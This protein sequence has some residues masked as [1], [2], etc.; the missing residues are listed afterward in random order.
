MNPLVLRTRV[1]WLRMSVLI[2]G[3]SWV[4]NNDRADAL[5][6]ISAARG[7]RPSCGGAAGN[8][9]SQL[10]LSSTSCK[11]P[12]DPFLLKEERDECRD[13]D[14]LVSLEPSADSPTKSIDEVDPLIFKEDADD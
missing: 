12:N 11:D 13:G 9:G 14:R 4:P 2:K 7:P 5:F 10:V 1:D 8:A 6:F 3:L